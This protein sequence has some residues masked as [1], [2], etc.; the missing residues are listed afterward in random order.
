MTLVGNYRGN[1]VP[2]NFNDINGRE[3]AIK[4]LKDVFG[5]EFKSNPTEGKIDL[6]RLDKRGGAD[7]EE[8]KWSGRYKDQ[9]PFNFN[10]F[11]MKVP[12]CQF[13]IR[14]DIPNL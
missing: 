13:Q 5:I 9:T 6:R 4:D 12:T 1:G 2:V 8:G 3:H 10:Q 11:T 7:V 14:K